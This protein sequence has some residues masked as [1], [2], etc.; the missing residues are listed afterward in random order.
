[1]WKEIWV[2]TNIFGRLV[3]MLQSKCV[4]TSPNAFPLLFIH[5]GYLLITL[6]IN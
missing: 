4:S 2:C 1:M 5:H 6:T 3:Y